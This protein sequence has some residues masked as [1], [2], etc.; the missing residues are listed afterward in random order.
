M[1]KHHS[2]FLTFSASLLMLGGLPQISAAQ[3]SDTNTSAAQ[4]IIT[5]PVQRPRRKRVVQPVEYWV[6]SNVLNL[7][8]NPVAGKIVGTLEYGQKV[9]AYSQYENWVQIAKAEG[10]SKWVNSDFLS[11]SRLSWA[12]YSRN[13][14]TRVSDISAI[15][16]KDP[17]NK[18]KKIFG[19]R[20]KT[21]ATGNALITTK[22]ETAQGTHFQNRFVS[23]DNERVIGV[24]LVG[25]GSSFLSAQNDFRNQNFD[26]YGT[27]TT[28]RKAGDSTEQ[29]ISNFACKTSAF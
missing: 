21:A 13:F 17:D 29:A 7:R 9:L 26:V 19:V 25:E 23:C 6:D 2:K 4:E 15:P 18:K 24:E 28:D 10:G 16:I 1:L 20:L 22:E 3:S 11:N 8:D 5:Q 14:S 27:E 12:S